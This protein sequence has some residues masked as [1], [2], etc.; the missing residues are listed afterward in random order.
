VGVVV[1]FLSKNRGKI[2]LSKRAFYT[3]K[4]ALKGL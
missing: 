3:I 4:R 2:G 1:S